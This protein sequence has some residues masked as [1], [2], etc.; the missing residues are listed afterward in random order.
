MDTGATAHFTGRCLDFS[1][2]REITPRLAHGMNLYAIGSKTLKVA[3][4]TKTTSAPHPGECIMTLHNVLF[5]PDMI[6]SPR[7][8]PR[9]LVC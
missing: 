1:D 6:K 7:T 2:Y 4:P 5:V 9:S 8:A 3:F